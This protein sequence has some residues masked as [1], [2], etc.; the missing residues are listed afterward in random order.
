MTYI[1]WFTKI[2][3]HTISLILCTI[4]C[5]LF[6]LQTA[7]ASSQ[8]SAS[9][10]EQYHLT[11]GY[12]YAQ[13]G[14]FRLATNHPMLVG[15]LAS[16]PL[17]APF[18]DEEPISLQLE[19]PA[20]ASGQRFRFSDVFLW[21]SDNNAHKILTR[22]R[23][24]MLLF[25][26]AILLGL[27]FWS[28]QFFSRQAHIVGFIA[29]FIA[30]F[31]PNLIANARQVTNDLA[32]TCCLFLAMW[33]LWQWLDQHSWSTLG[34]AGICAGLALVAK[35]SGLMFWPAALIA[36]LLFPT[37]HRWPRAMLTRLTGLVVISLIA[38]SV[39]WGFYQFEYGLLDTQA[40]PILSGFLPD[41]I[42]IPAPFYWQ[43]FFNTF[44]NILAESEVELKFLLGETS[45]TG[46]WYYFPVA[47]AA[48][49]PIPTLLLVMTG[50][51]VMLRKGEWR[52]QSPLW[53][54][55]CLFMALGMTGVLTIGYRHI[56]PALPFLMMMALNTVSL[57]AVSR[58][59]LYSVITICL[60]WIAISTVR[61]FP[62]QEA[63]FNEFAGPWQ[64]WSHILVDSN[65]DWGQDL[66]QL[67]HVMDE[68]A[69]EEV[70]LAYF[71][72]GV[73]EQYDVRYRPLPSYLRFMEGVELHSY[74]PYA[75]L[76]G[77]Y[78]ISATSLRLGQLFPETV[79]TYAYFR[80]HE[81]DARAGYSIYLYHVDYPDEMT[82]ERL[83]L[84]G[85]TSLSV[86]PEQ[87]MGDA[88]TRVQVKWV[89]GPDVG[90][91]PLGEGFAPVTPERYKPVDAN[92]NDVFT[93]LG[94][95]LSATIIQPDEIFNLILYWRVGTEP[96]PM[97]APT[98]GS[99]LS[100]FVHLTTDD[101]T[102][103]VAQ[104]DGW[105]TALR[106]LEPTD[107]VVHSID[108][109]LISNSGEIV[110]PGVY[111][112][113]AGLY[114]PQSGQRLLS[115]QLDSVSLDSPLDHIY[116]GQIKVEE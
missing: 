42:S 96:M 104:Y 57:R 16:I 8:K 52:Q 22:A 9:F 78:A 90:I 60:L 71:G 95:E 62:H 55:P 20:W 97:P 17:N 69:I 10:D 29:L 12:A 11:A 106:G 115:T 102:Q 68:M 47:F 7:L 49:T 87:L 107:V 24:P 85:D 13:T 51:W 38:Y 88:D 93:L 83:V 45:V 65:L 48:K 110:S 109:P 114:S 112:V 111:H 40:I 99:P 94:A 6:I 25:G 50:I 41:Q 76:P 3:S 21:E 92:L 108:M 116:L 80:A 46:W 23:I 75:P 59:L 2:S 15:L 19:H 35:Y 101:P 4:C 103:I 73:P 32:V 33:M 105:R 34:L 84:R 89:A 5:L 77:W 70:N 81:P 18:W 28:K 31:D 63:Y 61:I 58:P 66:I 43:H 67:R 64:N 27:F 30:T 79:D 98:N 56:L 14:D 37:K 44:G 53:S 39:V 86:P 91:A 36:L 26:V 100:T 72:K 113:R 1:Q 74:N 82:T 54:I